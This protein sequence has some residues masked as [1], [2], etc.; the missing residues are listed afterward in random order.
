MADAST[1]SL[2][3]QPRYHVMEFAT[4]TAVEEWLNT[5][6]GYHLLS[7]T[8]V[9][10]TNH[11]TKEAETIVWVVAERTGYETNFA[12]VNSVNLTKAHAA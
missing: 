2:S 12:S 10:S 4:P 6:D 8:P 9:Q 5:L 1:E 7:L 3:S 11:F